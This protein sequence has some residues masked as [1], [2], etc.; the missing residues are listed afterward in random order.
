M[1][2]EP[3]F[4]SEKLSGYLTERLSRKFKK[5]EPAV[6]IKTKAD[7][8]A[9]VDDLVF[10]T[11][12]RE[13]LGAAIVAD[14]KL[15]GKRVAVDEESKIAALL[16]KSD[17]SKTDAAEMRAVIEKRRE[18][19]AKAVK[20]PSDEEWL[21]MLEGGE[22]DALL[23]TERA[24]VTMAPTLARNKKEVADVSGCI[25]R[26]AADSRVLAAYKEAMRDKIEIIQ[27][28]RKVE[29]IRELLSRLDYREQ[30]ITVYRNNENLTLTSGDRE[31]SAVIAVR[32]AAAEQKIAE[33]MEMPEVYREVNRRELLEYARAIGRGELVETPTTKK[34][35]SAIRA[36]W[37][38]GV[39]V[40]LWGHLGAG[41]TEL[42]RH[43][44]RKYYG[45]EPEVFS[46]SEE[47][48]AHNIIGKMKLQARETPDE[49][50]ARA[51][52]ALSR[53]K[54]LQGVSK[55]EIA[56]VLRLMGPKIIESTFQVGPLIKALDENKPFIFDEMDE[57]PREIFS[58][59]NDLLTRRVGEAI[60]VPEDSNRSH[61]I[62]G[63]F[64]IGGT[65][66]VKSKKYMRKD[67]DAAQ[68][69]RWWSTEVRYLP[70]E[71]TAKLI[72]ASLVDRHGALRLGEA[73][74][75]IYK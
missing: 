32:R 63:G 49:F 41:K 6:E 31:E 74:D 51:A 53:A 73:D 35:I 13:D 2:P 61:V 62:R 47:A 72:L 26:L 58:R 29:K 18:K 10:L 8:S 22:I 3:K 40:F 69:S 54:A 24:D 59:F 5:P 27:G 42:L 57:I 65:G 20:T 16:K 55:N 45:E 30:S 15:I 43:V 52:K 4:S 66:N 44:S 68:L 48:S 25:T 14:E 1:S 60:D 67:L 23:Q 64:K 46:G 17:F 9:A 70:A 37:D 39:P 28:A 19:I 75:R 38:R 56:D 12:E 34:M 50:Y 33:F 7:I 36:H 71:E 11:Q 21:A